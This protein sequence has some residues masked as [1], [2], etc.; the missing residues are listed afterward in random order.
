MVLARALMRQTRVGVAAAGHG[1][2]RRVP[3]ALSDLRGDGELVV[4]L[5][6]L[7]EGVVAW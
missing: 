7:R 6:Q 2:V 1:E 3:I 5:W 4:A